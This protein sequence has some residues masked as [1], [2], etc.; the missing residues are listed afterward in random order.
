MNR[1]T[2]LS[3]AVPFLI[4]LFFTLSPCHLVT[5]SSEVT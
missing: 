5:L 4:A 2:F 3:W 1:M